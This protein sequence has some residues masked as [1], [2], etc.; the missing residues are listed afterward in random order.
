[1]QKRRRFKQTSSRMAKHSPALSSVGVAVVI[2][3]RSRVRSESAFCST[4]AKSVS[5]L[6]LA[7]NARP[8]GAAATAEPVACWSARLS[9]D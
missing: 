6:A 1:M 3:S 9:S 7:I 4:F 8:P 2:A 5:I